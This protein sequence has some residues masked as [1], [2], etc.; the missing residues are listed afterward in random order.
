MALL[1]AG[2]T[3]VNTEDAELDR[4]AVADAEAS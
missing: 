3:D 1:R 4:H 2:Q